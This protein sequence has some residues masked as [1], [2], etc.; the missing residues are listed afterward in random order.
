MEKV[1]FG[2]KR[3]TETNAFSEVLEVGKY[4]FVGSPFSSILRVTL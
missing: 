1:V 3:F 2:D 4:L